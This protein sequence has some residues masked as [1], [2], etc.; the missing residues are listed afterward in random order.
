MTTEILDVVQEDSVESVRHRKVPRA[1]L[2]AALRERDGDQCK[3]PDCGN[4]LNF[5]ITDGP[6]EV[7]L[8]HWIPQWFGKE[9][10]WTW[11]Q[12]WALNNLVLMHKKCNAKKGERVPN[13][14]GTLPPR[15]TR[16]FRYRRQK[17]A[18][19]PEFCIECDNGHNLFV[20]EICAN[21][22]CNAQRFPKSAKVRFDECDHEI[23]WCW[24]CSITPD[25][26]PASV[27][28]AVLQGESGEW[29]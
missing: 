29:D 28:T 7:T 20:G 11:D 23:L 18:G 8:D 3:Y 22:G 26:R 25:M 16:A 4:E 5:E 17:R 1:E 12:I 10:G 15:I 21:C 19:R 2:V 13:E 24:V 9:N 14:D 27:D 6:L